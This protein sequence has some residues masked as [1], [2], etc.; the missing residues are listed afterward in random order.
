MPLF[1]ELESYEIELLAALL[2]T[3]IYNKDE[4]VFREGD[5]GDRFYIIESGEVIITRERDGKPVEISRRRA[6]EY[7]GEIAL[8]QNTP[9][10]ATVVAAEDVT[11]LSLEREFFLNLV[12]NFMN[13]R[14]TLSRTS[15]RRLTFTQSST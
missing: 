13:L 10:T 4:V 9:R 12:S 14:Q 3:E 8:L 2:Q 15:T 1:D 6:G 11:L 5:S 7:L